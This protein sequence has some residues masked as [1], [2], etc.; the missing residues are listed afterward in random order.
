MC[1]LNTARKII[2][3]TIK[4][5]LFNVASAEHQQEPSYEL[6]EMLPE[7]PC[8]KGKPA[9]ILGIAYRCLL[10]YLCNAVTSR[11]DSFRHCNSALVGALHVQQLAFDR[12]KN[13]II[14][15]PCI[16]LI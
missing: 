14:F 15:S 7:V 8:Y 2:L 5:K 12:T 16:R 11:T 13:N 3:R 1:I 6:G 9:D 4:C 10:A